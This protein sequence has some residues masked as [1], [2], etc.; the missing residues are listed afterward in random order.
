MVDVRVSSKHELPAAKT[1]L[2]VDGD[3]HV[4]STLRR[5]LEARNYQCRLVASAA[6][7]RA[8]LDD[9]PIDL[10]LSD[11]M[12]PGET[13][14]AL[15][16]SL[17]D[18]NPR[19]PV[20]MVSGVSDPD[21]ANTTLELGAYGYVTKPFDANQVVIAVNNAILRS[22]LEEENRGYR[23][24]LEWMV[25]ERTVELADALGD[26]AA[27]DALLRVSS[28]ATIDM[29][30]QA[31]EGRDTETGQHIARMSR[32]AALLAAAAASTRSGAA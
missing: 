12:L 22:R 23:E 8:A 31:I 9:G 10:V 20:V 24:Q 25:T 32:Y 6:E 14:V 26:L 3:E 29:L 2:V 16:R 5:I 13:G 30:A 17:R 15:L 11:V 21:L 18:G 27:T 28:E 19:L 4:R 1:V 7:A